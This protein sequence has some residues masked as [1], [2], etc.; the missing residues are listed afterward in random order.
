MLIFFFFLLCVHLSHGCWHFLKTEVRELTCIFSVSLSLYRHYGLSLSQ[1]NS[2]GIPPTLLQT[3]AFTPFFPFLPLA[4][5]HSSGAVTPCFLRRQ[6][7][8]SNCQI[9]LPVYSPFLPWW[10]CNISLTSPSFLKLFSSDSTIGL[11]YCPTLSPLP[12]LWCVKLPI[13]TPRNTSFS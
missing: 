4:L 2:T 6:Q 3:L 11:A 12:S 9:Q 5:H 10:L 7:W 8:P 1:K 13:L